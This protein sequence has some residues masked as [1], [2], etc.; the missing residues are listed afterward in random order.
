MYLKTK[1]IKKPVVDLVQYAWTEGKYIYPGNFKNPEQYTHAFWEAPDVEKPLCE[2]EIGEQANGRNLC[3][4][5]G[6]FCSSY[7][8]GDLGTAWLFADPELRALAGL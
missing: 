1:P 4:S 7:C 2:K 3:Q 5:T 6:P 8:R